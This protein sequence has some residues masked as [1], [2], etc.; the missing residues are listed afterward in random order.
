MPVVL[1]MSLKDDLHAFVIRDELQRKGVD[2]HYVTVDAVHE[3]T[4][5]SWADD[6]ACI[7]T[8][9]GRPCAIAELDTIWWRR[10]ATVQKGR[11]SLGEVQDDFINR[12]WRA[13]VRGALTAA[14]D[15]KWIS[16]PDATDAASFKAN[17]LKVAQDVGLTVPRTLISNEPGRVRQF[18]RDLGDRAVVKNVSGTLKTALFAATVTTESLPSDASILACPTIYQEVI[19]G[20]DHLRISIFGDRFFAARIS[21]P[22]LDWRKALPTDIEMVELDGELQR[23]LAAYQRRF[24]LEMGIVDIKLRADGTPIWLENNPQGQF[25]FVEGI[26]GFPLAAHFA[27]FLATG[28]DTGRHNGGVAGESQVELSAQSAA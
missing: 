7:V 19:E 10:S 21:T 14:F 8:V 11:E 20:H 2:C 23:R 26:T 25:L 3:Q 17:Q 18:I 4:T 22:Q 24:S 28:S 27:D 9:D 13:G 12:D 1:I 6:G 15:G 16:H 5:L